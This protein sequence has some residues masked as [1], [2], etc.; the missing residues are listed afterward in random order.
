MKSTASLISS[1]VGATLCLLLASAAPAAADPQTVLLYL[2]QAK[3]GQQ[4]AMLLDSSVANGVESRLYQLVSQ[5]WPGQGSSIK[6]NAPIWEHQLKLVVPLQRKPGSPVLLYVNGGN[7][8][9]PQGPQLP[10]RIPAE[11]LAGE[12]GVAVAELDFV[13]NQNL[14]LDGQPSSREDALVAYSWRKTMDQPQAERFS[15]LHLPMTQAVVAAMDAIEHK[16]PDAHTFV[17]SGASKRGWVSWLAALNDKRVQALVPVVA[18]FWNVR[19]NFSHVYRSYGQQWPG[20]LRDYQRNGITE[21][22][23]QGSPGLDAL[24]KFEDVVNYREG[25]ARLS[26][27]VISASGDDFAV[28]DS[29]WRYLSAFNGPTQLRYLPNQAHNVKGQQIGVALRQFMQNW[30][31][32]KPMPQMQVDADAASGHI[33]ASVEEPVG[34]VKLWLA[35]NPDS[36]DFRFN[37]SIRYQ[38]QPL[39]GQCSGGTCRFEFQPDTTQPGWQA[40]F[41]EFSTPDFTWT[42]P[43]MIWPHKYVDDSAVLFATPPLQLGR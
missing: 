22:V 11:A 32:G 19:D 30:L 4:P 16:L 39:D 5:Q 10:D 13:P 33:R 25:M 21:A 35:H 31:A 7:N 41:M 26:K 9:A 24:L 6:S 17:L 40:Y 18:D 43:P 3:A 29:A 23:L 36:R 38:A 2:Q 42:T 20:A 15:S 34:N 37:S 14:T 27:Y 1:L 8:H 28:P 12:L